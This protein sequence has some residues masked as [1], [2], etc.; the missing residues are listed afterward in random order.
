MQRVLIAA[1]RF[2]LLALGFAIGS[3]AVSAWALSQNGRETNSDAVNGSKIAIIGQSFH[4]PSGG[5]VVYSHLVSKWSPGKHVEAGQLRCDGATI[6]GTCHNDH[7]VIER[8]TGSS[9]YCVQGV[10][11]N[12]GQGMIST[13]QRYPNLSSTTMRGTVAGA[14]LDQSGFT[15]GVKTVATAWGEATNSCP[16][17]AAVGIFDYW[18]KLGAGGAWKVAK[19]GVFRNA[20]DCWPTISTPATDG[21]FYVQR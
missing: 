1:R 10:T 14:D 12:N 21:G 9:Y 3:L 8:F 6:D 19:S 16:T 11:F 13:I 17:G 20:S 7:L 2:L 15:L 18:D 4:V 5:C